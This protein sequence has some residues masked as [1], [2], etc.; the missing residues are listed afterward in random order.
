MK[1]DY[2]SISRAGAAVLALALLVAGCGGST[3]LGSMPGGQSL[4]QTGQH[5]ASLVHPAACAP[6]TN[7]QNFNGTAIPKGSYIWFSSVE[8]LGGGQSKA[9]IAMRASTITFTAGSKTYTINSPSMRLH[10]GPADLKLRW[11]RLN[12]RK[13]QGRFLMRAPSSTAGNDYL[14]G[15]S[16]LVPVDLPGGIQNVTWSA[17]FY[18]KKTKSSAQFNWQ[19]GAAVYT[20]F[21][22]NYQALGIKPLDDNHYVP[23]NS[24]H[25][26]TPENFKNYVTGG[27]TGGGG[28]NYT[29]GLGP[30]IKVTTC[31]S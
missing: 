31:A 16:Y 13:K 4:A 21:D 8:Q 17:E 6:V 9:L 14:N 7:S 26:G 25:A 3:G 1:N 19:W 5:L 11:Q 20:T 12:K 30:S 23:Y 22:A 18:S 28:A 24:D 2:A 10:I 29:G 15:I 27:A